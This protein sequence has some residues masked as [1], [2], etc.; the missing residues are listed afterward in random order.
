MQLLNAEAKLDSRLWRTVWHNV[1]LPLE[2]S[3][4]L[5][6]H[7][8][9]NRIQEML[10][11][12]ALKSSDHTKYPDQLSGGMRMRVALARALITG[13]EILL[14]DEPFA[15]LDDILRSQL[16]DLLLRLWADRKMTILFVTH[17]IAEAIFLSNRIAIMQHGQIAE[18]IDIDLPYPRNSSLRSTPEFASYY[19]R[20][21]R[22][23]E[24][25]VISQ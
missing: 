15:A 1:K 6:K 12:V 7:D 16:N 21:S 23:L 24:S 25:S 8:Q 4:P 14:L 17:N 9:Q 2:L 10:D 5:S 13:P 18:L 11:A 19:G 3:L 20:V 22:A